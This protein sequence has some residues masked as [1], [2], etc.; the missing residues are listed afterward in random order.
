MNAQLDFFVNGGVAEFDLDIVDRDRTISVNRSVH[1]D[2]EDVFGGLERR[3]NLEWA[4]KASFLP[5]G[6]L[7]AQV[8]DFFDGGMDTLE[9][10]S[11]DFPTEDVVALS[12]RGHVLAVAQADKVV[13]QPAVRPFNFAFGLR[14]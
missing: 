9:V 7:I 4:K 8:R 11:V 2:A 5:Q 10:I 3:G 14:G 13:L 1:A 12:E 6:S